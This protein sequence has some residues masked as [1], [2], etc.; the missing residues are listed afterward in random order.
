MGVTLL[1]R[2]VK[3][4]TRMGPPAA[5]EEDVR[6]LVAARGEPAGRTLIVDGGWVRYAWEL[7]FPA[8]DDDGTLKWG[9]FA[10]LT[11]LS[12]ERQH[13]MIRAWVDKWLAAGVTTFVL[14]LDGNFTVQKDAEATLRM[15]DRYAEALELERRVLRGDARY[16][17]S[18][19]TGRNGFLGRAVLT[20][21]VA[22][23]LQYQPRDDVWDVLRTSPP[24]AMPREG[25][26]GRS[27][28][29]PRPRS[30]AGGGGGRRSPA[31]AA[32][33]PAAGTPSNSGAPAAPPAIRTSPSAFEAAIGA[34]SPAPAATQRP[35]SPSAASAAAEGA[36]GVSEGAGAGAG[37]GGSPSAATPAF[38]LPVPLTPSPAASSRPAGRA[39]P[40]ASAPRLRWSV[41]Y[42]E[43][44]SDMLVMQSFR[45]LKASA[46][47]ANDSDYLVCQ[48]SEAE[49]TAAHSGDVSAPGASP[50][51][52]DLVV[53]NTDRTGATDN[54]FAQR[55]RPGEPWR[56]TRWD[57]ATTQR[58]LLAY[59]R[60]NV[61]RYLDEAVAVGDTRFSRELAAHARG[62]EL[63]PHILC[64]AAGEWRKLRRRRESALCGRRLRCR[65]VAAATFTAAAS[66]PFVSS[67]RHR[68]VA[69]AAAPLFLAARSL[70]RSQACRA[71]TGWTTSSTTA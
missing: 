57:V 16:V 25:G 6:D 41:L 66:P 30:P 43:G 58:V 8:R 69:T 15:R 53:L 49:A 37:D 63:H 34:S 9:D 71:T 64:E 51:S 17:R 23:L 70:A 12:Y 29:R 14:C 60:D 38:T 44:E 50:P 4:A 18:E 48:C 59:L 55:L 67:C 28:S 61:V 27:P 5:T 56:W 7:D 62:V 20:Q 24:P 31:P 36:T 52:S 19:L 32:S 21:L 45:R 40:T 35:A 39:S 1:W 42:A 3:D 65:C 33:S 68:R 26:R 54:V 11:K 13:A 10:S 47:M 46:L 22:T 2:L